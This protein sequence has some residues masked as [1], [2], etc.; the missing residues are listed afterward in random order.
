MAQKLKTFK[1]HCVGGSMPAI[2]VLIDALNP[3]QAR[4]FL[5]NRYPGYSRYYT[6]SE[7]KR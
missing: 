1:G 7:V 6:S 2:E 4:A 5:A 3:V